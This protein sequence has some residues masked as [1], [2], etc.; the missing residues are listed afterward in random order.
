MEQILS[1]QEIFLLSIKKFLGGGPGGLL[2]EGQAVAHVS[3]VC[4]II[5]TIP[6]IAFIFS[7]IST[8]IFAVIPN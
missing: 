6:F 2:A 7:I 5:L 8:P 3:F 1:C 4:Q